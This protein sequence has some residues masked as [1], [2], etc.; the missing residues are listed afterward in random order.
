M[1]ISYKGIWG[2]HPLIV[3]LAN[4]NEV[5]SLVNRPSHEGAAAEADRAVRL[6]LQ[7]DFRKVML[8]G[9]TDFSQTPYLDGWNAIRG[10]ASSS[11]TTP[12]RTSRKSRIICR[13][14]IGGRWNARLAIRSRRNRAI[15]RPTSRNRWSSSAVQ[16]PARSASTSN[17]S[18]RKGRPVIRT[19]TRRTTRMRVRPERNSLQLLRGKIYRPM[20]GC[21][22]YLRTRAAVEFFSE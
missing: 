4:T 1:D 15:G 9:D 18:G 12:R 22:A 16:E 17:A 10:F 2:Y 14:R 11:A 19:G 5:L 21:F 3:S 7:A 8:R 20:S 6:C 13:K